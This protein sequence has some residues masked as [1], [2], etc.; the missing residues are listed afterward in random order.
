MNRTPLAPLVVCA[1]VAALA[2]PPRVSAQVVVVGPE[3]WRTFAETQEPGTT[4][5]IRLKNG[6]RFRA[7]LLDVS[8]DGITVQ[9][10]TRASVLPQRLPYEAIQTIEVDR[11]KGASIGKAV[12]IGAGV[13]AGAW[14][15]LMLFA[16]AVWGD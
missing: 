15:A 10:K 11:G 1:V 2:F 12:A 16:F 7:T 6:P 9:P 5:K 4:L 14:L 3:I 8:P 13:A